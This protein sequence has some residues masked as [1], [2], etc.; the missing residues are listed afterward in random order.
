MARISFGTWTKAWWRRL[1]ARRLVAEMEDFIDC[2]GC[3]NIFFMFFS[4]LC[5]ENQRVRTA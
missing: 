3:F 4:P 1:A 2:F 5:G